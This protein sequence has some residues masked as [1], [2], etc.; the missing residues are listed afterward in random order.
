MNNIRT[1][2][3]SPLTKFFLK[4]LQNWTEK[5]NLLNI[6][7]HLENACNSENIIN[8]KIMH[9]KNLKNL[10]PKQAEKQ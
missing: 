1:I 10:E 2:S 6:K 8:H 7:I 5:N 3:L 9:S 4:A